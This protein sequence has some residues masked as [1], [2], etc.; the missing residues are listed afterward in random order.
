MCFSSVALS[1]DSPK[2]QKN[3]PKPSKIPSLL[4]AQ[5]GIYIYIY[6]YIYCFNIC[7]F[8]LPLRF[9]SNVPPL[10]VFPHLHTWIQTRHKLAFGGTE[11]RCRSQ[12]GNP[13]LPQPC[14]SDCGSEGFPAVCGSV[15]PYLRKQVCA[16]FVSRYADGERHTVGGHWNRSEGA[17]K[18][19][20]C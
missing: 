12:R 7:L 16:G 18:K 8:Y 4:S 9:Y 17:N 13:L 1:Y 15:P 14:G 20:K 2:S 6:I 10:Y 11:A 3:V 19:D 5:A